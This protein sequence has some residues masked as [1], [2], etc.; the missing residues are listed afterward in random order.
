MTFIIDELSSKLIVSSGTIMLYSSYIVN[1]RE[2]T[3]E[4][5][6]GTSILKS[7]KSKLPVAMENEGFPV[8]LHSSI[9]KYIYLVGIV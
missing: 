2:V 7:K 3:L 4:L 8:V 9:L 6:T 1:V 5:C